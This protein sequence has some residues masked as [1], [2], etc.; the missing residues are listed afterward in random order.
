MFGWF[1]LTIC[2]LPSSHAFD[3][4]LSVDLVLQV[5]SSLSLMDFPLIFDFSNS[6]KLISLPFQGMELLEHQRNDQGQVKWLRL[7]EWDDVCQ[8][9]CRCFMGTIF[10]TLED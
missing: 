8:G 2:T 1:F 9:K 6:F 5:A 7:G 3:T 10:G 4:S